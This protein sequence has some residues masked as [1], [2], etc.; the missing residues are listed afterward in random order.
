MERDD[1]SDPLETCADCGTDVADTDRGYSVG[2]DAALCHGCAT[3][4]GGRWDEARD[5]WV[6]APAV[7]DLAHEDRAFPSEA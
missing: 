5:A 1:E 6:D 2:A 3:R 4:R 7:H